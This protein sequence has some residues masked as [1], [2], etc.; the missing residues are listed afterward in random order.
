MR[1][2][3]EALAKM[4]MVLAL[5]PKTDNEPLSSPSRGQNLTL[6]TSRLGRRD[7]KVRSSGRQGSV[8]GTTRLGPRDDRNELSGGHGYDNGPYSNF[9]IFL[10]ALSITSVSREAR[11]IW[12]VFSESCPKPSLITERGMPSSLAMLAQE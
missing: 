5:F 1:R 7:V 4:P 9:R 3:I 12:V 6:G 8:V 10:F 11:Y 2:S